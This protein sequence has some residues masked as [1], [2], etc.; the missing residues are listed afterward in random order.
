MLFRKIEKKIDEYFASNSDK[1]LIVTGA[2]Q[3]GKSFIIRHCATKFFKHI[4]EINLI[5]DVEKNGLF[6]N[7]RSLEDF[8]LTLAAFTSTP[9]GDFSDTLIFLDEI[10]E[11]PH[12]LTL[13]KF[14]R[15]DK[16][17]RYVASGSLLGVTLKKSNSVPLGSIDILNMFPLDFEE[18]MIASNIGCRL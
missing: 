17:Y 10:Q 6:K 7:V 8:Y 4:V 18:F 14:L 3:I 2:R 15:E 12:L 5:E 16:R 1:I 13:F 9:F 11:Y